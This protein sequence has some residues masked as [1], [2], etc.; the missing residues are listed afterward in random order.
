MSETI[1]PE[2]H[3][4][5][6]ANKKAAQ[7]LVFA[8]GSSL[9]KADSAL[10]SDWQRYFAAASTLLAKVEETNPGVTGELLGYMTNRFPAIKSHVEVQDQERLLVDAIARIGVRAFLDDR[11]PKPNLPHTLDNL[12]LNQPSRTHV[13]LSVLEPTEMFVPIPLTTKAEIKAV[14]PEMK[15]AIKEASPALMLVGDALAKEIAGQ[16]LSNLCDSKHQVGDSVTAVQTWNL[17]GYMSPEVWIYKRE[18]FQKLST[19][20]SK[21]V[22]SLDRP[23]L[24][25][26]S[27]TLGDLVSLEEPTPEDRVVG[28]LTPTA[29]GPAFEADDILGVLSQEQYTAFTSRY[30]INDDTDQKSWNE[31]ADICQL[32]VEDAVKLTQQT[33]QECAKE[34]A[35]RILDTSERKSLRLAAAFVEFVGPEFVME[36][37]SKVIRNALA[38]C[39]DAAL[40]SYTWER[41]PD[42]RHVKNP[43][44]P[45]VYQQ[46]QDRRGK[47]IDEVIEEEVQVART[48]ASRQV[49]R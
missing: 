39:A 47:E 6:L 45:T 2:K 34:I 32:D 38:T 5:K 19:T 1:Q 35:T 43:Q 29:E 23:L 40:R 26:T 37:D 49:N 44:Y 42:G 25:D 3:T 36:Q 7:E 15:K 4:N 24:H 18:E 10:V 12:K 33:K 22:L 28:K 46:F 8:M 41:K 13:P 27:H 20:K 9:Y 31:V 14:D 21:K 11:K 48:I 17:F 16:H 30:S